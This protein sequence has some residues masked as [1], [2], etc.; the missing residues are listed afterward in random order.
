MHDRMRELAGDHYQDFLSAGYREYTSDFWAELKRTPYFMQKWV[1]G[2]D[3]T[4]LFGLNVLWYD[5]TMYSD[6]AGGKTYSVSFEV[7]FNTRSS[8]TFNVDLLS[9]EHT[10]E[11]VEDFFMKMYDCMGC[12]PYGE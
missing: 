12:E 7:Q 3:G 11:G 9:G 4:K 1:R 2:E 10:L 8:Q 6:R 5:W